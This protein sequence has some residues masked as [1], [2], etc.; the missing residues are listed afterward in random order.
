V[1]DITKNSKTVHIEELT[2]V[3]EAVGDQFGKFFDD[4]VCKKTRDSL[5]KMDHRGVGSVRLADFYK[6]AV[7]D[8][9]W[10][11][12]E[13]VPYL[14]ELGALEESNPNERRVMIANYLVSPSN[15]IAGSGFYA[16]CCKNECEGLLGHIEEQIAAPE[17]NPETIAALVSALPSSQVHAPRILSDTSLQRLNEIAATHGGTVPLHGRLFG[18]WMHHQYPIECP[19][20]HVS[21][22]T[23]PKLPEEWLETT[24]EKPTASINQ[25]IAHMRSS[26]DSSRHMLAEDLMPW[27]QEEELLVVRPM[28]AAPPSSGR[29]K[30]NLVLLAVAGTFAYACIRMLKVAQIVPGDNYK[31]FVV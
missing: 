3:A 29:W 12:Q 31:K 20:P 10:Q 13:S 7:E 28:V 11:F 21:G 5:L 19:Y 1:H 23:D 8:G 18:Q 17:A 2:K 26:E 30:S 4:T 6:P 25:M 16:V 9:N 27:S 15:C 14:R 22:T 24:G